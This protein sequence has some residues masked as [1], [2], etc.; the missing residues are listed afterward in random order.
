MFDSFIDFVRNYYGNM[1]G[2]IFL[3]APVF[4]GNEKKYLLDAVDS[5]FVSSVGPYVDKFEGM[6]KKFTGTALAVA[7]VNGTSA[8]HVALHSIGVAHGDEVIT[9]PLSFV[10]TANAIAYTG[11]VPLF[12]DV[13]KFSLGLSANSLKEFLKNNTRVIGEELINKS[14][15]RKIKACVP[16]HSFGFPAD[17]EEI[18]AVCSEYGLPVIEDAAESLGSYVNS[19]H[20]GTFGKLGVFSFNGNK[21]ITCGG[22]GAIITDDVALGK[23][24][25][26]I[27]TTAK[28][29]HEWEYSHDE[30]GFNYRMPNLNAA[31]ACAQLE[32][33]DGFLRKKRE[34][35]NEY[36]NFFQGSNVQFVTEKEGCKANYWLNTILLKDTS[37]RDEF[38]RYTNSRKVMTRPAWRLL[39]TLPMYKNCHTDNLQNAR[40][41]SERIV[42]IPSSV[43]L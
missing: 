35:S 17:I 2:Q 3:H 6:M 7:A 34:L 10:A 41:L 4:A 12:L 37:E 18:V 38:L 11:A 39:N 33:L 30:L 25:K 26:H 8:L 15:G 43:R 32:E 36:K 1:D 24:I 14:T 5:T 28:I 23:R 13:D 40:E 42:N 31:L 21:T 22:G 16:V 20:T 29:P 27:T 9:Q 19:K